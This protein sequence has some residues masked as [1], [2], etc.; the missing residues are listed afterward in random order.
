M[1]AVGVRG[2][3]VELGSDGAGADTDGEHCDTGVTCLLGLGDGDGG[4][5]GLAV[6]NNDSDVGNVGSV[7]WQIQ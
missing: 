2:D 4:F 6:S 5:V 1:T 7:T 3:G